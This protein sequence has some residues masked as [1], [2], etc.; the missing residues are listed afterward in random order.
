MELFHLL[1]YYL[2]GYLGTFHPFLAFFRSVS[3]TDDCGQLSGEIFVETLPVIN[4]TFCSEKQRVLHE[5]AF[6]FWR[7]I[8]IVMI[9]HFSIT[10]GAAIITSLNNAP[11]N[12]GRNRTC[13]S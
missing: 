3:V 10:A 4:Q 5:L 2:S 9:I 1:A 8:K 12:T 7:G 6:L 13:T 11:M